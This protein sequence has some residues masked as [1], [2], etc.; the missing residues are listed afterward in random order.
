MFLMCAFLP[1]VVPYKFA[2][3]QN[4]HYVIWAQIA[5]PVHLK[6]KFHSNININNSKKCLIKY[7]LYLKF[8]KKK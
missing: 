8:L 3:G 5:I 7:I 1:S 2:H 4:K 6:L